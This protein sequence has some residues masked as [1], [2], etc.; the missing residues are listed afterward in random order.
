MKINIEE[1]VGTSARLQSWNVFRWKVEVLDPRLR[2][3]YRD[4][5]R[6]KPGWMWTELTNGRVRYFFIIEADG[7]FQAHQLAWLTLLAD[8]DELCE[9]Y[10]DEYAAECDLNNLRIE[11]YDDSFSLLEDNFR[12]WWF[13]SGSN[14]S[15]GSDDLDDSNNSNDS[16]DSD[17][18]DNLIAITAIS[19]SEV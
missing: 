14:N 6:I 11:L 8:I 13:P 7:P 1:N 12:H 9:P 17:D 18:S 15:D 5:E 19:T 2:E 4:G 3:L 16:D 10:G